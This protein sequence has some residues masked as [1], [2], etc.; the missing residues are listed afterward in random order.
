MSKMN[1]AVPGEKADLSRKGTFLSDGNTEL[2]SFPRMSQAIY[3]DSDET[4][5]FVQWMLEL[6]IRC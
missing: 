1:A 5:D 3:S 6:G 4:A 2:F